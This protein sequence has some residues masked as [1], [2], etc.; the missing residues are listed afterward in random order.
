MMN[1]L[2]NCRYG[3]ILFNKHDM[4]IGRSL[5]L[6][7]E[8]SEGECDVFRQLIRPGSTVLELGANI[9]SHTVMLAKATTSTGR[10]IAFE[11]QRIVFQ[12]LCAN[13]ALNDLLN[14][15]CHQLAVG[16]KP[17]TVFVPHLDYT[18]E[19]NFGGLGL[20]TYTHGEAVAVVKV[21]D[22]NLNACHFIK[23]DIEGM[24]REAILGAQQTI[25]KYKPV[26][27]MENDREDRSPAL[28]RL[29]DQLGYSM[30]WHTPTLFNPQNFFN[31]PQNVFGNV[32]SKNM[33]CIHNSIQHNIGCPRVELAPA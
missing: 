12:T 28:I 29:V 1:E 18:K 13:I 31:N 7:G 32:V 25:T 21:D 14:V 27:Y 11:P 22:L 4:Y 6:Y 19:N 16:E 9:G 10:V 33:I 23:I 20:G 3:R 26:L 5:D 30:Y 24:E 2:K 8:F 15:E 17:A